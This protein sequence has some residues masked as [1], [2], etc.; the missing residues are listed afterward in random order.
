MGN[1]NNGWEPPPYPIIKI[2]GVGR[3][4][5]ESIISLGN[6]HKNQADRRHDC[7]QTVLASIAHI[8]VST[9]E[10]TH[11][12]GTGITE[13]LLQANGLQKP[14]EN[15]SFELNLRAYQLNRERIAD[16]FEG[17]HLIII[18]AD[19]DC[20]RTFDMTQLVAEVAHQTGALAA[21]FIVGS[22]P[23]KSQEDS[24]IID[25]EIEVLLKSLNSVVVIPSDVLF[26]VFSEKEIRAIEV[27]KCIP[28]VFQQ[29]VR[30]ITDFIKATFLL[31]TALGDLK[32]ILSE[33][34][35]SRM[36]IGI[37]VGVDRA[38]IA[39]RMA[40]SSPLLKGN[41]QDAQS[42]LFLVSGGNNL[43]ISEITRAASQAEEIVGPNANILVGSSIEGFVRDDIQVSIIATHISKNV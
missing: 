8:T 42:I 40:L 13:L 4:G 17:A 20:H 19:I 7:S 30:D 37:G 25:H 5:I 43:G 26:P 15:D 24:G 3:H 28:E 21:A 9:S 39:A 27:N 23:S 11:S 2:V 12:M 32:L 41:L 36:G 29:G 38:Q 10:Q 22:C 33:G 35:F 1:I 18:V 31:G 16:T 34:G 14:G 6:A